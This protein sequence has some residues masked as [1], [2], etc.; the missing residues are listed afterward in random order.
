MTDKDKDHIDG[1]FD[2]DYSETS[3]MDEFEA[4]LDSE[5]ADED[6]DVTHET[7][8]DAYG[9]DL[10]DLPD[11]AELDDEQEIVLADEEDFAAQEAEDSAEEPS[12]DVDTKKPNP[13]PL[14]SGSM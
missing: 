8:Q 6:L 14:V 7:D 1:D 12:G 9:T 10:D 4:D 3:E 2:G 13:L 5:L 11:P